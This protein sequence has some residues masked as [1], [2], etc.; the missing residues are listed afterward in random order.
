MIK[1]DGDYFMTESAGSYGCVRFNSSEWLKSYNFTVELVSEFDTGPGTYPS[2]LGIHNGT[3]TPSHDINVS[4]MYTYP[5]AGTGGHTEYVE[6][7]NETFAINATWNGYKDDWLNIT[8][9][10]PFTLLA[11]HTYN[12]T[13]KTGSYPQIIHEHIVNV[14]GGKITCTEFIDANGKIYNNWIP[15]I[16][17]GQKK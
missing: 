5:C 12:Y 10:Y 15:A 17:F 13:I 6:L 11:N 9:T 8:F 7:H 1:K 4:R 3:I 14:T 16:R 2:I